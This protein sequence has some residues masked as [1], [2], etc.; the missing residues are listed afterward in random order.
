MNKLLNIKKII[1]GGVVGTLSYGIF[2]E[3]KRILVFDIDNTLI[4][5]KK[6]KRVNSLNMESY[7]KPDFNIYDDDEQDKILYNVWIRPQ[8]NIII[9]LL[10]KFAELHIFTSAS[11]EYADDILQNIDPNKKYFNQILYDESWNKFES[12][13]LNL[14]QGDN[15]SKILI[16][17]RKFN[18]Y[19]K[20]I[21]LFYHIPS[22]RIHSKCDY[23]L[24]KFFLKWMFV[25]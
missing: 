17:D 15:Q 10:S 22:Y 18:N 14:I 9:P 16:D 23:E 13:N 7:R 12:K 4:H 24:F 1:F 21:T 6:V 25:L 19:E 11:K 8:Y 2:R 3:H 5:A 20:D